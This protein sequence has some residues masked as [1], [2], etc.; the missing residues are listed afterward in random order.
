MLLISHLSNQVIPRQALVRRGSSAVERSP[1]SGV[2]RIRLTSHPP[3]RRAKLRRAEDGRETIE[4][5][6]KMIQK[7]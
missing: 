1:L 4:E 3:K 6:I 2:L 5:V 7:L